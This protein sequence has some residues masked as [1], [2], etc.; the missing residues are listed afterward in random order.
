MNGKELKSIAELSEPQQLKALKTFESDNTNST[1]FSLNCDERKNIWT[2]L[3]RIVSNPASSREVVLSSLVACRFLSRDKQDLNE[4]V[5]N[6]DVNVLVDV[7]TDQ[8]DKYHVTVRFEAKKV[9]SNL[10]QQSSV[11][12]AY[13]LQSNLISKL[14]SCIQNH[15][16]F[17]EVE[18]FDLRVMIILTIKCEEA[19]D[20]AKSSL[21][22][23]EKLIEV[24][25]RLVQIYKSS[26]L[27]VTS[28][29]DKYIGELVK[30]LFNLTRSVE[31]E[32]TGELTRLCSVL[33]NVIN[34]KYE[35][36]EAREEA[37]KR[38]IHL[39]TNIHDNKEATDVLF[40]HDD[41][42][43]IDKI[44]HFLL[45]RLET[46]QGQQSSALKE[47]VPPVLMV[48]WGLSKIHPAIRKHLKKKILPPLTAEDIQKKPEEGC[49]ARGRLVCLLT[50]ADTDI[51]TMAA[52]LLFV[53]CKHNVGKLVK[54]TG[55][56]NAAGLLA[57]RG[58]MCGGQAEAI[59]SSDSEGEQQD[60]REDYTRL[61]HKVNPIT[62]RVEKEKKSPFEGMSEE[63]KEYEAVKIVNMMN[64]LMNSGVIKPATVGEDGKPRELEHVLQL[65]EGINLPTNDDKDSDS[66]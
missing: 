12:L 39:L 31:Q 33:D 6:E 18:R 44:L 49:S 27:T 48:L 4:S 3:F 15:Q 20:D 1:V 50:S 14:L 23:L 51:A 2:N 43:N 41:M 22:G 58:L 29:H 65:Q 37:L 66:D 42:K 28:D 36:C 54:Q 34:L 32:D 60:E 17:D 53:L 59:F 64:Q 26:D 61:A 7:V 8:T 45:S 47:E 11:V 57:R 24:L 16:K 35:S 38:V 56:G 25:E 55:Y 46:L 63:Q 13:S 62:G 30:L 19:R 52:E 10:V 40:L 21:N 5:S 9:L